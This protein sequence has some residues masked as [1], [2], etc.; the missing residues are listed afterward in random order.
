M[1]KINLC[2]LSDTHGQF[3][4]DIEPVDLLLI[5][6]DIVPLSI[7]SSIDK[8][9]NWFEKTFV[10]WCEKQPA[11]KI[12]VVAGNHDKVLE[13]EP[14][15]FKDLIKGT[16][17][18]YLCCEEC[19][20]RGFKIFGSPLCKKFYNWSFMYDYDYQDSI[21]ERYL[22]TLDAYGEKVDILL[23]HDAPYGVSDII[24]QKN[25]PWATGENIGNHS[26]RS[27]VDKLQ[28][29]VMFHGHLHSTNHECEKL[30]DTDVYNVSL[31]NENYKMVYKPL[32]LAL[33]KE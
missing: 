10:P 33:E 17:I 27:F 29:S 3:G 31:L 7:Q 24:L 14:T 16:K 21:Y 11:E 15:F 28:P 26:L 13:K 9:N 2:A 32:Y 30:R 25:C 20:F 8:C 1:E 6:G 18:T 19:D 5:G 22:K 23:T 12:V 4:F